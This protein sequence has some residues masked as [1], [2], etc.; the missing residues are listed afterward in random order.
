MKSVSKS[1]FIDL[2]YF[3]DHSAEP[4]TKELFEEHE[5][6]E[7]FVQEF[8]VVRAIDYVI[9]LM[10]QGETDEIIADPEL[11]YGK[12]AQNCERCPSGAPKVAKFVAHI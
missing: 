5:N 10:Y 7:F 6:F 11:A 2:G 8:E 1:I 4:P 12:S 9:A 3:E